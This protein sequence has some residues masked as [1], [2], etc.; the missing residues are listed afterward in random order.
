MPLRVGVSLARK[1]LMRIESGF[2]RA[3]KRKPGE[4][5][6]GGL[7]VIL[8]QPYAESDILEDLIFLLEGQRMAL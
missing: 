3:S 5:W 6:K 1:F 2:K 8:Q 7:H 4:A